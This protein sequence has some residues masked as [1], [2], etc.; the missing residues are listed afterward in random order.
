MNCLVLVHIVGIQLVLGNK[1]DKSLKN[2][3]RYGYGGSYG[4]DN[5]Y[6]Y[7]D[8]DSN[9]YGDEHGYN[10]DKE[11]YDYGLYNDVV[12]PSTINQVAAVANNTNQTIQQQPPVIPG[13]PGLNNASVGDVSGMSI[14][15]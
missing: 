6:S 4:P 7:G 1:A 8:D 2:G 14:L 12:T 9:Y 3:L 13:A 10:A 15:V 11:P 5:A